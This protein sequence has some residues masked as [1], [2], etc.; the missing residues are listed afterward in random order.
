[1]SAAVIGLIGA[2]VGALATLLGGMLTQR[3][4]DR[5]DDAKWRRDKRTEAYDGALR[6]LLRAANLRS[7]FAGGAGEAV[8][9]QEHQREWFDDLVQAQFWMHTVS[10]YCEPEQL[11]NVLETT[12]QLD[13]HIHRLLSSQSFDQKGFS[14]WATLQRCITAVT[15]SARADAGDHTAVTGAEPI[16]TVGANNTQTNTSAT[17]TGLPRLGLGW[18]PSP[19]NIPMRRGA[20]SGSRIDTTAAGGRSAAGGRREFEDFR[21]NHNKRPSFPGDATRT[22]ST[23]KSRTSAADSEASATDPDTEQPK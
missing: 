16:A 2:T 17:D 1:M 14:I 20:V 10:Q 6:H 5:R 9:R 22:D 11:P 12:R 19:S 18:G 13:S 3:L 4:Q 23:D 15:A 21:R 7:E 8:L